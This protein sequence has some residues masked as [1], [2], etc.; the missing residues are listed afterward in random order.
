MIFDV[1]IM[2]PEMFFHYVRGLQYI[3]CLNPLPL[4]HIL[5]VPNEFITRFVFVLTQFQS[6]K[7]CRMVS[8]IESRYLGSFDIFFLVLAK[9]EGIVS[10]RACFD[11]RDRTYI[12]GLAGPPCP[13]SE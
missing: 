2:S 1:K 7:L 8:I 12:S 13:A 4:Q 9:K 11:F 6:P 10:S 5:Y 3:T